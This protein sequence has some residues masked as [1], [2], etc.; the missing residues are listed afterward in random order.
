MHLKIN[1]QTVVQSKQE[2]RPKIHLRQ[3][4][5]NSDS[6][7]NNRQFCP[8]AHHRESRPVVGSI[9]LPCVPLNW[10]HC[11]EDFWNNII[12]SL[13]SSTQCQRNSKSELRAESD[14]SPSIECKFAMLS[15]VCTDSVH[16]NVCANQECVVPIEIR[17]QGNSIRHT[18]LQVIHLQLR[19]GISIILVR[20]PTSSM[21]INC[22]HRKSSN[23]RCSEYKIEN[24]IR[25]EVCIHMWSKN[26]DTSIRVYSV[27]VD[28]YWRIEIFLLYWILHN[29]LHAV[30][31]RKWW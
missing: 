8:I 16:L 18:C 1:Q 26:V 7:A 13:F 21:I 6:L 4:K 20:L 10:S 28:W 5:R 17:P 30:F 12:Q 9:D 25:D 19:P 15:E 24:D 3:Y 29:V 27:E 2:Q 11:D 22:Q 14:D 23:N 31:I